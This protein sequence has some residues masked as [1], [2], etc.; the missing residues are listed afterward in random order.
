MAKK[1]IKEIV[2]GNMGNI[3]I[4]VNSVLYLTIFT[5]MD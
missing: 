1:I 5:L 2:I 4:S 3:Y